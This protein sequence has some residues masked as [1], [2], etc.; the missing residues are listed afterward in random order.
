M[1]RLPG[2]LVARLMTLIIGVALI[3]A[4]G[5]QPAATPP[6]AAPAAPTAAPTTAPAEPTTAPTAAPAEPTVLPKGEVV[7]YTSRAEA[8][9]KPVIEAFNAAYPD[10]KVTVL[11][12]SNSELAARILEERANPKADVLVNSDILTMENLAAEGVFAPN[13]SPAVMA[14]PAD[15]RADDGSWVALTLRARVIMYNTDLVSLEELPKKMVD[16]ADP[17]WKDVIGSANSTNGAMMAQLVIMRNQLGEPATEAFIQGLLENNAQFFGGHT[18]VRKAVGAGE[19]KL[20]LVNHYYYHLSKAE[21]APVGIIYPDQE[22]GGLG[23]MVNSTN[24][25]I[26][27]GGP[28]PEMA[29]IFVDFMLSPAGQKIYAERNYEYPIVPGVPL[30]EGV[31]PLDSFRLNPFPLK[32][33][34]DELE[35]TRAL[36]Q[37]VGMP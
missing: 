31:A 36:V 6:T 12:G 35:P 9:F 23:L 3:A 22:D 24:A 32:T 15:Y 14:V 28:N 20:G 34:R 2:S 37:K 27:K 30:A 21:G 19:L 18:D 8:L 11:N 1:D 13:N 4:C 33:L 7:V 5:G 29:R 17:K 10:I 26:I 25:G 16:L